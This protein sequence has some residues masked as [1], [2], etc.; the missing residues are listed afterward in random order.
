MNS[1]ICN[2]V[3]YAAPIAWVTF[4]VNSLT[5]STGKIIQKQLSVGI[6]GVLVMNQ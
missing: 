5:G 1:E 2:N 4:L 6:P 3:K